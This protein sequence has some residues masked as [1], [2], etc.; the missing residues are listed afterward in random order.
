MFWRNN[1]AAGF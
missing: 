1:F